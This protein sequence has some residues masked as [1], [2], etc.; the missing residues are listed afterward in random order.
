MSRRGRRIRRLLPLHMRHVVDFDN[1]GLYSIT[2]HGVAT[3]MT[4]ILANAVWLHGKVH[5]STVDV[6]DGTAGV[7]GNSFSFATAFRRVV[8]LELH[9]GRWRLLQDN[10]QKLG[11]TTIVQCHHANF[12]TYLEAGLLRHVRAF[13]L[14]PP[15]GGTAY[16]QKRE[17]ELQLSGVPLHR[18]VNRLPSERYAV[19]GIKV[20]YNFALAQF[21]RDLAP[22]VE[23][24]WVSRFK[25]VWLLVLC[26]HPRE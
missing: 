2:E 18:L 1:Q 20:P 10:V 7:G 14:D 15:W 17:L 23:L 22:H 4:E 26:L 16:R 8:A 5:P 25:H 21:R 24:R 19:C 9:P 3:A 12:S 6:V 13:F 11:L